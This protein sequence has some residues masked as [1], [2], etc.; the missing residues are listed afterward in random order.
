MNS[1]KTALVVDDDPSTRLL[2]H[3]YLTRNGYEVDTAENGGAALPLLDS[4]H[5][6]VILLDLMMPILDGRGVIKHLQAHRPDQVSR[7][8]II[9]AYPGQ[10]SVSDLGIKAVVS[11]PF[12]FDILGNILDKL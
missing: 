11:K 4:R 9:T 5:Y 2:L 12:T 7:V 8:V 6:H 10:L 3:K 1:P